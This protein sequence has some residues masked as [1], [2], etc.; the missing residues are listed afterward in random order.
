MFYDSQISSDIEY[1]S[2]GL[3][4]SNSYEY[5]DELETLGLSVN[6]NLILYRRIW[7]E[8]SKIPSLEKNSITEEKIEEILLNLDYSDSFNKIIDNFF[9]S[10]SKKP[11]LLQYSWFFDYYKNKTQN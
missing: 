4:F 3:V 6:P 9:S 7:F 2:N 10:P 11:E 1:D 8:I 5:L